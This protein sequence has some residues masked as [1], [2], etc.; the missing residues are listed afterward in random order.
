MGGIFALIVIAAIAYFGLKERQRRKGPSEGLQ[1]L[2]GARTGDVSVATRLELEKDKDKLEGGIE[3]MD[4]LL[5]LVEQRVREMD[6]TIE[7]LDNAEFSLKNSGQIL[8]LM[9]DLYDLAHVSNVEPHTS[10]VRSAEWGAYNSKIKYIDGILRE[11]IDDLESEVGDI[12]EEKLRILLSGAGFRKS[13]GDV[14]KELEPDG[15]VGD[16]LRFED[17]FDWCKEKMTERH[18][19]P[20]EAELAADIW[21]REEWNIRRMIKEISDLLKAFSP[22]NSADLLS[23]MI[24]LYNHD[25]YDELYKPE[26]EGDSSA[27]TSYSFYSREKMRIRPALEGTNKFLNKKLGDIDEEKLR[28]LLEGLG[29]GDQYDSAK[30]MKELKKIEGKVLFESVYDWCKAEEPMY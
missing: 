26:Y 28:E 2:P 6:N 24:D 10:F 15:H 9:L 1:D 20:D 17:I 23:R 19:G 11:L 25:K 22:K 30:V 21:H 4:P 13:P 18:A 27:P 16:G 8:S 3:L 14:M 29:W 7:K 12:D 5:E